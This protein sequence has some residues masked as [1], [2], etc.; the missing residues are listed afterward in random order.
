M[1]LSDGLA[2]DTLL[3]PTVKE[4]VLDE[5]MI[6]Q[7]DR[8]PERLLP[9]V[10]MI[11]AERGKVPG[12]ASALSGRYQLQF[13]TGILEAL[14]YMLSHQ[15]P[16]LIVLEHTHIR[17]CSS[18][19]NDYM[20]KSTRFSAV[21]LLLILP[22]GQP[23]EPPM[24]APGTYVHYIQGPLMPEMVARILMGPPDGQIADISASRPERTL[25][26]EMPRR[27]MIWLGKLEEA[28]DVLLPQFSLTLQQVA[29]QMCMSLPHLHRKIKRITG[30]TP[31]QFIREKRLLK[32][33]GML[34][35]NPDTYV[36]FV[37]H[38][39]GYKSAK[40]FSKIFLSRFGRKPSAYLRK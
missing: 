21:Q 11:G 7:G 26:I 13:K 10:L 15:V 3:L 33:K 18:I 23:V 38:S 17:V 32:S 36:K 14:E 5:V 20:R 19:L 39:V 31:M 12:L 25:P 40:N 37:A 30:Y 6:A 9:V 35:Q 8:S 4:Q 34:E 24:P 1:R 2:P 27:D 29:E 16:D 28:V 22:L